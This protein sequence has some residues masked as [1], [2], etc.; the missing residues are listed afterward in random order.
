MKHT[1]AFI[2]SLEEYQLKFREEA[3]NI[4]KKERSKGKKLLQDTN[5]RLNVIKED[6]DK[7]FEEITPDSG[8]QEK[9]SMRIHEVVHSTIDSI[10]IPERIT[11][12]SLELF[13][14]GTRNALHKQDEILIKYVSLLKDQSYKRR[15]KSL[16]NSL[17]RLNSDLVKLEKFISEKYA[18]NSSIEELSEL[19]TDMLDLLERYNKKYLEIIDREEEV[20]QKDKE[21]K[22]L[23][24]ELLILLNHEA[25]K[26][27]EAA[28]EEFSKLQR[29]LDHNF[30]NIRKAIRKFVNLQS[31][32][33][34][35]ID[36]TLMKE[37]ITDVATTIAHQG[38][39]GAIMSILKQVDSQMEQS[40]LKLKKDKREAARKDISVLMEGELEETWK[41]VKECHQSRV[42]KEKILV[43][44]DLESKIEKQEASINAAKRDRNR[45]IE[46]EL[47][48]LEQIEEE[49]MKLNS[50]LS[51]QDYVTIDSQI[52][53]EQLPDWAIIIE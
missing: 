3:D 28:V 9:Y 22:S 2:Q 36:T 47:R 5:K 52:E 19:I 27:Y 25:K 43:D 35:P 29:D 6:G 40:A 17:K 37:I 34:N 23:E 51:K 32:A 45:I 30:S 24:S 42:D 18:P 49:L 44:L 8:T 12:S 10:V 15:V 16:S 14:K 13:A 53:L 21:I 48:D 20:K 38:S 4:L 7:F 41:K 33:K 26:Q 31:K 39:I 11:K 1:N 50:E 46:R